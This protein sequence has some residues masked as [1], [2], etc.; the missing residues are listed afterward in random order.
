MCSKWYKIAQYKGEWW[1]IDG[2]AVFADSDVGDRGHE[3][4]VIDQIQR[5][6]VY[7]EFDKGEYVD[8][9]GFKKELAMEAFEEQ[10][11]KR[12]TEQYC[13][14]YAD[15]MEDLYLNKLK[16]M[17]MSDEEY[18]IAE[19]SGN[20]RE[21]G[22]QHL[23]W[24]RVAGNNIETYTLTSDDLKEI[25]DGLYDID[26]DLDEDSEKLFNISVV[27]TKAFYTDIPYKLIGDGS[28]SVLM[29]F[30]NVYA[31]SRKWYKIAQIWIA[32]LNTFSDYLRALYEMEYKYSMVRNKPFSG[33]P[34]RQQNI[35]ENL[36]RELSDIITCL[37]D[38]LMPVFSKWLGGHAITKPQQWAEARVGDSD[39]IE[40]YGF[41]TKIE[42]MLGEYNAYV[43]AGGPGHPSLGYNE[44]TILYKLLGD[45]NKNINRYPNF[46]KLMELLADDYRN[47]ERDVLAS[48]GF[49]EYG[50]RYN[51]KFR[52][53]EQAEA[54]IDRLTVRDVDIESLMPTDLES[55]SKMVENHGSRDI[56]V[57]LYKNLVFPAWYRY[58]Q[59]RGIKDTRKN[60]ENI[61]K[62]LQG[63]GLGNIGNAIAV[64]S[65][66]I[67]ATH[68]SGDMLDYLEDYEDFVD[69]GAENAKAL[70]D[71][72]SSGKNV[73]KWNQELREIGVQI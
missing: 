22:M 60:I 14:K 63:L 17:G 37:K 23:G 24:K 52:N 73:E 49:Q 45:V 8:W 64:I 41:K 42:E 18:L 29:R 1:I 15:K 54:F 20:A 67:N 66:A 50:Q 69:V 65:L 10:Y 62:K 9:R 2:A 35:I 32:P 33:L 36:G 30:Q 51:K 4:Y 11:G 25:A 3:G 72:L 53:E 7:N 58:W 71:E 5:K 31:K 16:E 12:P 48:E 61:Y 40:A 34:E 38:V 57:E 26:N 56:L 21:Y 27:S 13:Q 39:E 70:L 68:Q 6:Y 28:P 46:K 59:A 19:G 43:I 44:N 47:Y 55:F